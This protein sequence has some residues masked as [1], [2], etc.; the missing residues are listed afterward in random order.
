[1]FLSDKT[2]R[3]IH[4]GAKLYLY[5]FEVVR[6]FMDLMDTIANAQRARATSDAR[7]SRAPHAGSLHS[8]RRCVPFPA[9]ASASR[10][11]R[12]RLVTGGRPPLPSHLFARAPQFS[13]RMA[14]VDFSEVWMRP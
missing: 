12:A 1:M 13:G 2:N 3:P 7:R 9:R 8:P 4:A 11:R 5:D 14:T 10:R 6:A